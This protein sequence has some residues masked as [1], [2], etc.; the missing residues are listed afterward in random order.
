MYNGGMLAIT[1]QEL[2]DFGRIPPEEPDSSLAGFIAPAIHTIERMTGQAAAD[3][4]SEDSKLAAKILALAYYQGRDFPS[5]AVN[6]AVMARVN[7]L[8]AADMKPEDLIIYSSPD[9]ES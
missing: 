7:Q 4:S 2:R 5:Q 6:E 9:T 3:L 8:C 1:P